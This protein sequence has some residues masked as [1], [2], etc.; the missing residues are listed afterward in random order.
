MISIAGDPFSKKKV[1]D[2]KSYLYDESPEEFQQR[3]KKK[4]IKQKKM[5]QRLDKMENDGFL[6]DR[7]LIQ[8]AKRD[9]KSTNISSNLN[10]QSDQEK[11][12]VSSSNLKFSSFI[13]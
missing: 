8:Q 5:M 7:I 3:Q 4:L 11:N 2:P 12:K 10:N 6:D 9:M 1:N 13:I